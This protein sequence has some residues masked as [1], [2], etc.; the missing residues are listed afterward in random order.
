MMS[1]APCWRPKVSASR[2]SVS[3]CRRP[4][5]I[6]KLIESTPTPKQMMGTSARLKAEGNSEPVTES[7][8]A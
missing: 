8:M 4:D 2:I 6:P 1:G 5:T 3:V 7:R